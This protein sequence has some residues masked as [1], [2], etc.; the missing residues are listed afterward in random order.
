MAATEIKT[1]TNRSEM[2]RQPSIKSTSSVIDPSNC[3]VGVALLASVMTLPMFGVA[4]AETAPERGAISLKYLDYLDSQPGES[5]IKVEATAFNVMAP[6]SSEWSFGATVTSDVISGASPAYHTSAITPMHDRRRAVDAEVVRYLPN[7][8][9]TF[10]ANVSSESDYVSRGLSL[11]ATRSNESKNTTW[12][13]GLG[14]SS[15][16][17]NPGNALVVNET[18]QVATL[19]LGVTQV[20]TPK[21]IAQFNVGFTNGRGYF[22]DPYKVMENR[23]RYKDSQTLLGRWNH[24]F[25]S[26]GGTTRLEYRYY[27]DTWQI[28]AHTIG[29]EYVQPFAAGWVVTPLLRLYSQSAASCYVDAD[30]TGSPFPP[31]PAPNATYYSEYQR[32]SAYGAHT[33]GVKVSK[34]LDADWT[35]DFKVENYGQR[36][37]WRFDGN[38]SP[39]LAPFDFRSFQIGISRQF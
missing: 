27:S 7:G 11:K 2:K 18:K 34:K 22:D 20:L 23:P 8:T 12:S 16:V 24:Y 3:A 39:N 15:D 25:D 21:D 31:N 35:I 6:I 36:S 33:L 5:R 28:K 10:S 1:S 38:G 29:V 17:I 37:N 14:Y 26:T 4:H 13:A 19:L 32:L 9:L 30:A